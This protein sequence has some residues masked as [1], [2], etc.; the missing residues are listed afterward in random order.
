M[1]GFVQ[2]VSILTTAHKKVNRF[3][4]GQHLGASF[5]AWPNDAQAA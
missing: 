3:V 4:I 5:H 2:A 1:L